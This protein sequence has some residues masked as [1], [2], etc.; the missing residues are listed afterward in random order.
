M[1][2]VR[3]WTRGLSGA[4]GAALLVP[5]GIIAALLLLALAG[6]FGRLGGLGQ[7]LS[8]PAEPG[9]A[10]SV[11]SLVSAPAHAAA[12]LPVVATPSGAAAV[13]ARPGGAGVGGGSLRPGGHTGATA[14]AS[15][16]GSGT[17]TPGPPSGTGTPPGST[18]GASCSQPQPPPSPVDRVVSVGTSVTSK[19]PGALG[20]L[21][22]Q[23]LKQVGATVDR[24]SPTS[25][26]ANVSR[27]V[28]QVS[29]TLSQLKLP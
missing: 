4:S 11:N 13:V 14:G 18:C 17:G 8:G 27:T 28:N 6:S 7:A 21:T 24:I 16:S 20:Q 23:V 15:S 12:L 19:L 29:A 2:L 22:T 5:G 25:A 3:A 26:H 10:P 1:P 9:S